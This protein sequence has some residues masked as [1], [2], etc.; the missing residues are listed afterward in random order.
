[1]SSDRFL[2]RMFG[3]YMTIPYKLTIEDF[4]PEFIERL[5][6][7][8]MELAGI[9]PN[10][11]SDTKCTACSDAGGYCDYHRPKTSINI[12]PDCGNDKSSTI[13]WN[14][15]SC[16]FCNAK[17]KDLSAKTSVVTIHHKPDCGLVQK[18]DCPR[19]TN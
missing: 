12:C 1:M 19:S 17:A 10:K 8:C 6:Q 4:P 11:H 18:C 14:S 7:R 16:G 15:A 3:I 2:Y 13:N 5:A 9:T